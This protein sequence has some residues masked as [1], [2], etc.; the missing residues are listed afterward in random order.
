MS[1]EPTGFR[2]DRSFWAG[3][4]VLVTGHTGFKGSWLTCWLRALGSQVYGVSLPEPPSEPSLWEQ[5]ALEG[6]PETRAD[7]A[8]T[9][10]QEQVR[11][12]HPEVVLHLAAQPLV[13]VGY[14]DPALT[15]RTNVQGTVAV[16][17]LLADL[18]S[19]LASVVVTTDKVYDVRQPLPF[20]EA[21]Y[22]GGKD[23]YSASKAAAELVVHAWPT[24]APLVTARAGNVVGGGDW[25]RDRLLPDLVRAWS[26]GET[27]LLRMPDAV[28]PWQ[29][30]VEPLSGYLAY[31]QALAAGAPVPP[32]LN[33]GPD[34]AAAVPVIDV[35]A[36]A[37][38][39]WRRL[40][41][42]SNPRWR[43]AERPPVEE[44][45]VLMLDS[46]LAHETL[47]WAGRWDWQTAIGRT[48]EWY[49]AVGQGAG[50]RAVTERQ[51]AAYTG[52]DRSA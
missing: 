24:D 15:F 29:H 2:P 21:G 17:A 44:T 22:L 23:P 11:S 12:F 13:T 19:L 38:T 6:V 33:F 52:E 42:G 7:I 49:V 25:G 41:P 4:R 40:V 47:G 39:Q 10:W 3:R 31:A 51:V 46:S 18:P 35:V 16:V 32:A 27:A 48:L 34:A 37:A 9:G 20:S 45:R 36:V 8:S 28:R 30:V 1:A 26:A 5:L 50:A 14:E 43:V